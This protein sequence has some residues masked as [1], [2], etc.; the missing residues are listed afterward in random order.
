MKDTSSWFA[1]VTE[2]Y[3]SLQEQYPG[4]WVAIHGNEVIAVG[5]TSE[6]ADQKARLL[7]GPETRLLIEYIASGDLHAFAF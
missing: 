3:Q 1:W 2:N 6:E 7:V 5:D 4:K